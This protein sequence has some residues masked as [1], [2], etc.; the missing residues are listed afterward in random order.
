MKRD[1]NRKTVYDSPCDHTKDTLFYRGY[2]NPM[3]CCQKA[4]C[5]HIWY[6]DEETP[7]QRER[8]RAYVE[9]KDKE[10]E[11][12]YGKNPHGGGLAKK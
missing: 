4:G 7:K 2:K 9:L 11:E 5:G 12:K 10:Y 1:P 8:N 6:E 3:R